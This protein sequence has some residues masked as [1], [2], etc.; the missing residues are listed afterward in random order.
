MEI[1]R[2]GLEFRV[3]FTKEADDV[4]HVFLHVIHPLLLNIDPLLLLC[5]F[6]N[7]RYVRKGHGGDI[8][9]RP[10]LITS[11]IRLGNTISLK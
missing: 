5:H 7:H 9:L 2:D 8:H 3:G 4:I 6:L 10:L 11:R 1:R